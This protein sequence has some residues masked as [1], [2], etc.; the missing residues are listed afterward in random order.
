MMGNLL[1]LFLSVV[2]HSRECNSRLDTDAG[3][4]IKTFRKGYLAYTTED[5]TSH[6]CFTKI[7]QYYNKEEVSAA[8]A[9]S[10][11]EANNSTSINLISTGTVGSSSDIL[12][13]SYTENGTHFEIEARILF[14]DY[15]SCYITTDPHE[16]KS[17]HLWAYKKGKKE[18][19]DNCVDN[20]KYLC[21]QKLTDVYDEDTCGAFT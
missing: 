17:C 18:D 12:D 16:S 1:L 21:G 6:L 7:R 9:L 13:I 19:L 10:Y 8:Y 2:L 4:V 5:D 20:L 14:S 11:Q 15:K 3:K